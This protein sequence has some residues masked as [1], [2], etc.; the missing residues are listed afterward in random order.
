MTKEYVCW[1]HILERCYDYKQRERH[2]AYYHICK[3]CDE[4]LNFQVFAEWYDNNF[5]EV[6][7]LGRMHIDKDILYPGNK[8]YSPETCIFVPQ[9]INM[10]FVNR[11]NKS[12]L[13]NGITK[14]KKRLF[15]LI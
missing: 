2:P 5:Y 6:P 10:L 7:T 13:P 15:S 1:Q 8:I 3:I 4:W 11:P 14:L 9:R 12:G